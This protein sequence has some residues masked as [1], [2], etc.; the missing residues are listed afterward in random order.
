MTEEKFVFNG[1]LAVTPLPEMLATIHRYGVPGVMEFSRDEETKRIFFA[2]GDV[3]F[4]T[5]SER[6]DSLGDFLLAKGKITEA[7][8]RVSSEELALSPGKRH[9]NVLVQMG[10]LQASELGAL[11]R[12]QVQTVLWSLFN[13]LEGRVRFDVGRFREDEVYK[14]KIPTPRAVLSGCKNISEA[15][16]VMARLGSRS[17][18]FERL[19]M[20]DHLNS[21]QLDTSELVL[22]NLVDGKTTLFDLCEKGPMG[23]GINARVLDAFV[24]LHMIQKKSKP[25]SPIK[26]Q[27]RS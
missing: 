7:Q 1:D 17:T 24:H 21:F 18:V 15:K 25:T 22:L 8:Y 13:W 3:I 6:G 4:A 11:V 12:E 9:G 26:I 16:S 20:P 5:S 10:F 23:P 2:D 27:V 19:P 14:I